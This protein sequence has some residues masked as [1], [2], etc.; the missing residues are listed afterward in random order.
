M[1]AKRSVYHHEVPTLTVDVYR[2]LL[3]FEV[4]DPCVQHAVKKLLCLGK[5]IGGKSAEQDVREAIWTL[6]RWLE[7]RE[8]DAAPRKGGGR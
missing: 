3:A 2:V 6:A 8:E 1:A 5:R 7:M 4:T